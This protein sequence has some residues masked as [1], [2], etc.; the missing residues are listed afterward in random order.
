VAVA[1]ALTAG[2][3]VWLVG[4]SRTPRTP[5]VV[6][7]VAGTPTALVV[8]D[9]EVW[10]AAQRSARVSVLD[11]ASGRPLG[12]PLRTGGAPARLAAGPNAIWVADAAR[13]IVTPVQRRPRRRLPLEIPAGADVTDL[14]L[15][16]DAVWVVSSAED[17][18]R[19]IEPGDR[20]R[21]SL[22]VGDN[23]VAIAA[24]R[25]FVAVAAAGD[26][27][28]TVIDAR[29]RRLAWP[30]VRVGGVPVAV[31][32]AD[33][34]AWVA[35]ARGTVVP[36]RLRPPVRAGAPIPVGGRPVAIAADGDDVYVLCRS[37]RSL[38][39]LERGEVRWRRE[40]GA[41]PSAVALDARHVWVAGA[42]DDTVMRYDL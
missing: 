4:G 26:G 31:A 29:S 22:R 37:E 9:G 32:I 36:V 41:D 23:P 3:V 42:G 40:V 38:I 25:H 18:V 16:A 19:A 10:V 39:Y 8:V 12:K 15:A 17:M 28:L 2:V 14:A 6:V 27:T 34:T 33:D 35:D 1:L 24:D 21:V 11:A 7:D 30:P 5:P 20:R 13:A